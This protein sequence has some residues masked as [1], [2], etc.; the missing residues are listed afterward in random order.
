[1]DFCTRLSALKMLLHVG[2]FNN[3][4]N[5]VQQH[6]AAIFNEETSKYRQGRYQFIVRNFNIFKWNSF[7]VVLFLC[8]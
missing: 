1:M 8:A 3:N 6:P 2:D 7:F 4:N 5:K